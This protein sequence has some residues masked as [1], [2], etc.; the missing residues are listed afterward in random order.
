MQ[1]LRLRFLVVA[2]ASLVGAV[3]FFSGSAS[4]GVPTFTTFTGVTCIEVEQGA[5][6]RATLVLARIEPDGGGGWNVQSVG[7]DGDTDGDTVADDNA[8]PPCKPLL[9]GNSLTAG[10]EP[11]PQ[12]NG[13]QP[14]TAT[15]VEDGG[16]DYLEWEGSCTFRD[17]IA[18]WVLAIFRVNVTGKATLGQNSGNLRVWLD[19]SACPEPPL[20]APT[21]TLDITSSVRTSAPAKGDPTAAPDDWDGDGITDWNELQAGVSLD[22]FNADDFVGGVAEFPDVAAAPLDSG[23]SSNGNTGLMA[24]IAGAAAAAAVA[25][26]GSALYLSRRR[27]RAE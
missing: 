6:P 17:D 5:F 12:K 22:P 24:A 13:H 19:G 20:P 15:L 1:R 8:G 3:L 14:V 16:Q 21:L 7:Y 26:G 9:D 2:L 27:S 25:L 11:E 4:A 23:T 18:Q 10:V